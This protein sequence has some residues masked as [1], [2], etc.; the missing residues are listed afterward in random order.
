VEEIVKIKIIRRW[1]M[2]SEKAVNLL[3]L[4]SLMENLCL[5]TA[6]SG[7]CDQSKCLVGFWFNVFSMPQKEIQQSLKLRT[8]QHILPHNDEKTYA[9]EAALKCQ[10]IVL[11]QCASCKEEHHA[12]CILNLLR[13]TFHYFITRTWEQDTYHYTGI[14]QYLRHMI[15]ANRK[16]GLTL[17]NNCR[18][19]KKGFPL[20]K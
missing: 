6:C 7:D 16:D 11:L 17:L 20:Q 14:T 2:V 3:P 10:T 1:N 12:D 18:E 4:C 13:K 19:L 15:R 5:S 9:K 8:L